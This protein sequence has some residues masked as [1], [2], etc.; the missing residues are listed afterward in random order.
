MS[1]KWF[2]V[3]NGERQGPISFSEL[4]AHVNSGVV[5]DDDFVW[6]KRFENW[7]KLKDT[8]EFSI[9]SEVPSII[10]E[11]VVFEF[12]QLHE[13][14]KS[15]YI[16]IGSDR[17]GNETEY[18]PFTKQV[19]KKLFEEN[20]VNEKTF[21]FHSSMSDWT[22]LADVED[23]SEFFSQMPPVIADEDRR[24]N[25]RK[26]FVA[27][28]FIQNNEEVFEGI[29]RD[30][31]VGG[32]QVLIDRFPGNVGN[33]ISINVHPENTNYHFTASGEIVR[34]LDGSGGFSFRFESL[35]DEAVTS[36]SKYLSNN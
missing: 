35:S 8:E 30:I 24:A 12:S 1:D 7:V 2:F 22:I 13:D 9:S 3:Q 11:K 21:I 33:K 36:I 25:T 15:V 17:G 4:E 29:C 32:M 27:R 10:S 14:E 31:S 23:F 28:M 5:S 34:M 18:G 6:T 26:P 19:L 16:K 20:R